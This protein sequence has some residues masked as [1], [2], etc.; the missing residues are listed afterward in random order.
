MFRKPLVMVTV[1]LPSD[2]VQGVIDSS[3]T[4][5]MRFMEWENT[6]LLP[7]P[8]ERFPLLT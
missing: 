6:G 2:T 8:L 4:I 1:W 5:A 7:L 3:W